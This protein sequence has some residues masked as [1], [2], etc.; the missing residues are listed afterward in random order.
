MSRIEE[1]I[2]EG[3]CAIAV[4]ASLLR[5][6]EIMRQLS[7][8]SSLGP[9]ALSGPVVQPMKQ[10]GEDAA[11]R[12]TGQPNGLLVLVDPQHEDQTGLQKLGKVLKHGAHKPVVVVVSRNYNPFTF[13]TVFS[14][15]KV[16]HERA[17]AKL[18]LRDLPQPPEA[19]EL[20][21]LEKAAT[22]SKRKRGSDSAP[23]L[24][25]V[26]REKKLE[27]MQEM[28]TKGG[29]VVVSGPSGV[30]KTWFAEQ[31]IKD[32]EK[33]RLPD[34]VLGHWSGADT[35]AARLAEITKEGGS[36]ALANALT[37]DHS[38]LDIPRLAIEALQAAEGAE[39]K[40]MV[41]HYLEY[42]LGKNQD[43]FRKSRLEL[44]LQALLTSTYPMSLVFLS[45]RQPGFGAEGQAAVL[46][47]VELEGLQG[48]VLY[49]LF[50]SY[51][52]PEFS[53]DKIG[54]F[55]DRTHGNPMAARTM[56]V[57]VREQE[58]GEA[59]LE[60]AKL[61]K[62]EDVGKTGPIRKQM[63]RRLDALAKSSR[64]ELARLAHLSHP[65]EGTVLAE[66]GVS[67]AVRLELLGAGLLDMVPSKGDRRY[68]VHPL[69]RSLM[70]RREV[71]D[72]DTHAALG[73]RYAA[74]AEKETDPVQ[75][76][77]YQQSC[78]VHSTAGRRIRSRVEIA[79]PDQDGWLETVMSML[80]VREPRL[81]MADNRVREALNKD[82][83][84][85]DAWLLLLEAIQ[86][87]GGKFEAYEAAAKEALEKAPVP[88]LC[89]Q[90]ATFWMQ[91]R[92]RGRA[93]SYLE[94]GIE[95][96][97]DQSRL[98]TR[99]ASLLMRQGRRPEALEHLRKAM[100]ID[101]MLA[102]AYGLLGQARR[103]EGMESMEEAE[104]L[105]R[106]AVR[107]APRDHVQVGRL[108]ALLL[109]RARVEEDGS[110][111]LRDEARELLKDTL[112]GRNRAPEIQVQ[113]AT[114]LREEGGDLERAE[115]LLGKAKPQVDRKSS[116]M[117][118]LRV[119]QALL[120]LASG[121]V[122]GAEKRLREIVQRDPTNHRAF[123]A[124]GHVLEA[125]EMYVPAY[126]EYQRAKERSHQQSLECAA[127]DRELVRVQKLIEL[128]AAGLLPVS[129]PEE[130][131]EKAPKPKKQAEAKV[132]KRQGGK[133][134]RA[135]KEA[136][137]A[138]EAEAETPAPVD[139][140]AKEA[141][142]ASSEE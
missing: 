134:R 51:K 78:N 114:L 40:V 119:E 74:W 64:R 34:L 120:L 76:L 110:K 43:F 55:A 59:L 89:Q 132:K 112:Q 139:D 22:T 41:V 79:Y 83:S 69:V 75:K 80:R 118:T 54:P 71:Q 57:M 100:E 38:S 102:D 20:P 72:F 23:Q 3:R 67:R 82:A 103:D 87:S 36:D 128:Q 50:Q 35:L 52:A 95:K 49:D 131:A 63:Q 108:T 39:N 138:P 17:R 70:S 98:R 77:A 37:G 125:R 4:S 140:V 1:A 65:V 133:K 86:K 30:G 12:V 19:S 21:E 48:K 88:E 7:T 14:G 13:G 90:V 126:A 92:Q 24:V 25:F 56:A 2:A 142:T 124:I 127:H 62:L 27:A 33:A 45:S 61:L 85:S 44:L 111:A 60:D 107:L 101:P 116:L 6:A 29:P 53:R 135:A 121:D 97:P 123:A 105:L 122:D 28:I 58:E 106:E 15:L 130:P 5:D 16:E 129:K 94:K 91:R 66:L 84:N 11:I 115:W 8:R 104:N 99:L 26:G 117:A 141:E 137:S 81:E 46:G 32:S 96:M 18:W 10:I 113:L 136:D 31:A 9:M 73:Q 93:M 109:A 68:R 42:G 47:Q